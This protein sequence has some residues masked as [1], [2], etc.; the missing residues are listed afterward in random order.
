[1][2]T[3]AARLASFD[4]VVPAINSRT[5][6]SRNIQPQRWVWE[7]PSPEQVCWAEAPLQTIANKTQ[8]AHAGFYFQ[9][10]DTNPDNTMCFLC[11]RAL[12]GWEEGD[13]PVTEHLKHS[14]DCGWAIIMDIQSKTSNPAEI[15]DPTSSAIVEARRATFAIG[16]PHEGKRGWICQSEKVANSSYCYICQYTD[17]I[18]WSKPDG[19]SALMKKA[20][21]WPV[22]LT[23]NC[24]WMA[25]KK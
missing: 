15:V 11:G 19:I 8:L 17:R 25:G 14:P 24:P 7:S 1:M 3:F 4:S 21:T 23:A 16:W 22:A 9:P 13:D 12:D 5:S 10:Y 18:R 2:E 6:T 20:Q